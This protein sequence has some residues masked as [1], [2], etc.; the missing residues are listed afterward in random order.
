MLMGLVIAL[1][2]HCPAM[3]IWGKQDCQHRITSVDGL[4][5]YFVVTL[6]C[7]EQMGKTG[8]PTQNNQC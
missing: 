6:S 8:W 3:S 7:Y 1:L 2:L 4:S 5:D